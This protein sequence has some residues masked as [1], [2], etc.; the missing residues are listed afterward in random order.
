MTT[1][2]CTKLLEES[3]FKL[4]DYVMGVDSEEDS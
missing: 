4:Q 3:F 2:W 1:E